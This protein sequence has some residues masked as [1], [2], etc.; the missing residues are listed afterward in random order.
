MKI[1][2]VCPY[3][4]TRSGGVQEHVLA[5]AAELRQRG[6]DIKILT[7]RPR[8]H[9]DDAPDGVLFVGASTKIKTPIKTS[10]EVGVSFARDEVE[11]M[12]DAEKFDL[13]HIHEPEVPVLGAQIVAKANCPVVATF[14]ALYPETKAARTLESL[15]TPLAR[16]ILNRVSSM[17]AVSDA[18]AQFVR[19]QVPT[20]VKIIPNGIDLDKYK[21]KPAKNSDA[22][23]ILYIGRLEKRK[24]VR[25]LLKAF[26]LL[27]DSLP[28]ARL[29]IAGDGEQRESLEEYAK[30]NHLSGVKFLGFI[31]EADKQRLLH[32][33]NL[34]CSPAL[35][36]ESF[37]IVLLE[38]MASGTV[39]V[40]GANP[41]YSSVLSGTG[42]LSLVDPKETAE[43]ARRLELLLTD[44]SL[45]KAW[46]NWAKD[47]V[48]QF[49]YRR[50]VDQYEELYED[51]LRSR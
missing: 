21:F 13:L 50:V 38:A 45:R 48:Q 9:V 49:D 16:P 37:G 11:N 15:R 47:Y 3:D 28:E 46:L 24:G 39:T 12:L 42:A 29:L 20:P 30:Q 19:Q 5:Q 36:G 34:F 14:H 51:C 43:F 40:A 35:Y 7:P 4:I 2:I 17:T 10:L 1:G 32:E 31:E 8:K 27:T 44:Q 23:T 41:G 25:Y 18:A 26:K 22:P 33:A 6:H